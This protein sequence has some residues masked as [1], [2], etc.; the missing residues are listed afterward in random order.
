MQILV[1]ED[2]HISRRLVT[3]VL[4][5]LGYDLIVATEW[6]LLSMVD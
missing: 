3:T 2:D 1:V 4:K 6:M 5:Q